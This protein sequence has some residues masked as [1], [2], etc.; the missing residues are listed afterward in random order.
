MTAISTHRRHRTFPAKGIAGL[1]AAVLAGTL[2]ITGSPALAASPAPDF[3]VDDLGVSNTAVDA[4][5]GDDI[6]ATAA[7]TCTLTA[8]LQEANAAPAGGPAI[9]IRFADAATLGGDR[10]APN[11]G[12][13]RMSASPLPRLAPGAPSLGDYGATYLVD[14][15]VPVTIDFDD[16]IEL[17]QT[18]D[19]DLANM[20][21]RSNDV[22]VRNSPHARGGASSFVIGG[23]NVAIE[24][25]TVSDAGSNV[26]EAGIGLITGANDVR[27]TGVTAHSMPVAAIAVAQ[28]Q[29]VSNITVD[30][31]TVTDDDDP[32][33]PGAGIFFATQNSAAAPTLVTNFTV[34]NSS[35]EGQRQRADIQ[36]NGT[37][38]VVDGLLIEST[39]FNSGGAGGYGILV[40]SGAILRPLEVRDSRFLSPDQTGIWVRD[41]GILEGS[42]LTGNVSVN[43]HP[44]LATENQQSV[45]K[46]VTITGN[47]ITGE[48]GAASALDLRSRMDGVT[49]TGNTFE[50]VASDTAIR[51]AGPAPVGGDYGAENVIIEDN[52]FK[53]LDGTGL[54][55]ILLENEVRNSSVRGN[56]FV[57]TEAWLDAH[58]TYDR[59]LAIRVLNAQGWSITGNSIDGYGLHGQSGAPIR[60]ET[61]GA[62]RVV[63]NTFGTRTNGTTDAV[64]SEAGDRWFVSNIGTANNRLQTLRAENVSFNG[65]NITFTTATVTP[66]VAGNANQAGPYALHVYWTASEHAEEYLGEITGV[67]A[68]QTVSIPSDHADGR[69]RL[70]TVAAS[71]DVS[72][73]S[74]YIEIES[75]A[76]EPPVITG[77]SAASVHGSGA[78]GAVVT[79]RGTQDDVVGTATVSKDD[80]TW[81]LDVDVHCDDE[82]TATQ[83]FGSTGDESE[84]SN[85]YRAE[86]CEVDPPAAPVIGDAAPGALFGLG[87]S[88]AD[89]TVRDAKGRVLGKTRVADDGTWRLALRVPCGDSLTATQRFGEGPVSK[90]SKAFKT[91][92]CGADDVPAIPKDGDASRTAVSGTGTGGSGL[93]STGD[94][95]LLGLAGAAGALLLLGAV[96]FVA[97]RRRKN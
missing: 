87:A 37:G 23:Q 84:A 43:L 46:D 45:L 55:A 39:T 40:E 95:S 16:R 73:Y 94:G 85:T 22:T 31:L 24:N 61:P 71:G 89:V 66:P 36:L 82:F 91:S 67:T 62:S 60:I 54:T 79:V 6:C 20:L 15:D 64:E 30:G 19:Y 81:S 53:N 72:Q 26:A 48:A 27:I 78:P 74:D 70:Q 69:I 4:N 33:Q 35:F 7:N 88:G 47:T 34:R 11:S 5:I 14:A 56:E 57:Q 13:H 92:D 63:G 8:A 29:S 93:A 17:F 77:A 1:A 65:S 42:L 32:G 38:T 83:R 96:T 44:L 75:D 9:T 80:G 51:V 21:I 3:V 25:V 28:G 97:A 90:A 68:G 58:P 10:I 59:N 49:I 2:L 50:N 41:G 76:P 86:A 52:V 12:S 18:D